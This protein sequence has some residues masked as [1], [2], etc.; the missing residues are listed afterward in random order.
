V[1]QLAPGKLACINLYPN[2]ASSSQLDTKNY[3]EYLERYVA[4]VKPQ[5]ISYD[6]YNV[7]YSMDL[8]GRARAAK[9]YTNLLQVRRVAIKHGLQFGTLSARIRSA[10][11]RRFRPRR[12]C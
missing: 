2:Y 4:E 9:Y 12:I 3:A 5:F 8:T 7:Q 1:K 10:R 6:N 11:T